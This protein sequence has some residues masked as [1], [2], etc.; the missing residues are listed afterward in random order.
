MKD[1]FTQQDIAVGVGVSQPTVQRWLR[2]AM[3]GGGELYRLAKFL[4]VAVEDLMDSGLP[5][6][7]PMML[8]ESPPDYMVDDALADVTEIRERAVTLER[9]LKKLKKA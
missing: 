9:K 1:R 5:V 4:G 8:R 6:T 7:Q 3:P 2:G